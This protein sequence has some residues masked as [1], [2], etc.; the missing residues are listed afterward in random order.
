MAWPVLFV[1]WKSLHTHFMSFHLTRLCWYCE[2][3]VIAALKPVMD[4]WGLLFRAL[5]PSECFGLKGFTSRW[6][7]R[8]VGLPGM[9]ATIILCYYIYDR[10]KNGVSKANTNAKSH[11]FFGIF[12]CC[13]LPTMQSDNQL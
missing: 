12:F 5:G 7:L 9:I 13:T 6:L 1:K 4:L 8:V 10:H 2:Q 3:D 11:I